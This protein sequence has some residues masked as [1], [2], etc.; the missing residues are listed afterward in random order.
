[1]RISYKIHQVSL[2]FT[3]LYSVCCWHTFGPWYQ[4][5][6]QRDLF[7]LTNRSLPSRCSTRSFG[8]IATPYTAKRST[9]SAQRYNNRGSAITF[10]SCKVDKVSFPFFELPKFLK[11]F[12]SQAKRTQL[13][14][15]YPKL[16]QGKGGKHQLVISTHLLSRRI[17]DR[18]SLGKIW[19]EVY[20]VVG[21]CF[22]THPS[23]LE[24]EK[25]V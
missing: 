25:K 11:I 14:A 3:L 13:A 5:S 20:L 19:D 2:T 22:F 8:N 17:R 23:S 6:W 10:L 21:H 1:M 12:G 4:R 24:I 9:V 7:C 18:N 16:V 15:L